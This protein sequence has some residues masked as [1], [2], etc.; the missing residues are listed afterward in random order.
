MEVFPLGLGGPRAA[1]A[2]RSCRSQGVEDEAQLEVALECPPAGT[3]IGENT[4]KL[5]FLSP[6]ARCF[7]ANIMFPS[8]YNKLILMHLQRDEDIIF[9]FQFRLICPP[10]KFF[11]PLSAYDYEN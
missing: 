9:S 10:P 11:L 2:G 5:S 8:P 4:G 3:P 7:L 1:R 6:L